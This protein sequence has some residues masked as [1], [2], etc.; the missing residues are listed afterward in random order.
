MNSNYQRLLLNSVRLISADIKMELEINECSIIVMKTVKRVGN[1]GAE[2][3]PG[4][5]IKEISSE[6]G[7]KQLGVPEVDSIKSKLTRT[8]LKTIHTKV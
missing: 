3:L 7:Y 4:K 5:K 6:Y 1:E 2:V 8:N